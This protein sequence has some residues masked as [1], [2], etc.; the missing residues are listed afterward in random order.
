MRPD[1]WQALI[2]DNDGLQALA[3]ILIPSA[4]DQGDTPEGLEAQQMQEILT[5]APVMIPTSILDIDRFW[6]QRETR[7]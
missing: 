2:D 3:P 6:R 7:H 5:N 4:A 1:D